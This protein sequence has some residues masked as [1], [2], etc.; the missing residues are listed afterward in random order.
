VSAPVRFSAKNPCPICGGHEGAPRGRGERCYGYLD[1]TGDYARCTREEY[2][3]GLERSDD[4]T[5]SHRLRGPCRCG[6]HHGVGD[7]EQHHDAGEAE[8]RHDVRDAD[9][10][11][12]ATHCRMGSGAGKR[13]WWLGPDGRPGLNGARSADLLYRAETLGDAPADAPL[14][15]TEGEPAADA[16]AAL[17]LV[18]VGTVTGARGTLSPAAAAMLAG[19]RVALWRD[20]D[21]D[22]RR[23]MERNAVVLDAAGARPLLIVDW[24][25]APP[26]GDAADF[27]FGRSRTEALA[28]V[29]DLVAAGRRWPEPS[30]DG[31]AGTAN[32]PAAG[33]GVQAADGAALLDAMAALLLRFV[34]MDR[35][36]VVAVVLWVAHTHALEA[37][38]ATLYLNINSAEKRSGKTRTIE[39][40]ELVV[41]RP[42]QTANVSAAALYRSV[43]EDRPTLLLDERDALFA[44]GG[45][46]ER[47]EELRGL[48]NAG[49]RRGAVAVRMAGVGAAMRPERYP[50]FC[51]K[52]LA[53][54]G[55]LPDTLADRSVSVCL[56]R[57]HRGE[58]IER[59]RRRKVEPEAAEL[60]GRLAAWAEAVLPAL[61]EAEPALPDAL[62]DRAADGWEPLVAIG[63]AAGGEWPVSARRAAV[64]LS[65]GRADAEDDSLGVRLLAH[66]RSAF[67]AASVDRL[68]SVALVEALVE[69]EEAPWGDLGGKPLDARRLARFLR[70]YEIRSRKIR[71]G[72]CVSQGYLR[73]SFED[74]WSRYCAPSSGTPEHPASHAGFDRSGLGSSEEHPERP[75]PASQAECSGVPDRNAEDGAGRVSDGDLERWRDAAAATFPEPSEPAVALLQWIAR[76]GLIVLAP[77]DAQEAV[78]GDREVAA[79]AVGELVERGALRSPSGPGAPVWEVVTEALARLLRTDD[80][81]RRT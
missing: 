73:E 79:Q 11:L 19:R 61:R 36:Q 23:H 74:A 13:V 53:G 2:A 30:Q 55:K 22:G 51:P 15:L 64:A 38:D 40:L 5:Y 72:D 8:Q 32:G 59:F 3:S 80:T 75:N 62:D 49:H 25:E 52:A 60:R 47:A 42:L 20:A 46:S 57:R 7:A 48:L 29:R 70:D 34:V 44:N 43:A 37:A 35:H 24:P 76:E 69:M 12:L 17:G 4:G 56:K 9:G 68:T 26:K 6:A 18:A 33:A 67:D 66:S 10:R 71:V 28:E 78:G 27:C 31:G 1:S 45:R 54:I 39:V 50:V 14:F 41:A 81:R 58:R 77:V 65:A 16:L 63:D 21:E